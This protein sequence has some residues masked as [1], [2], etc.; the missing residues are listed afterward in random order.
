MNKL[1][2]AFFVG[3][4]FFYDCD[5]TN[6]QPSLL[7]GT[8]AGLFYRYQYGKAQPVATTDLYDYKLFSE[9]QIE[10]DPCLIKFS[11]RGYISV[12]FPFK[13]GFYQVPSEVSIVFHLPGVTDESYYA[14]SGFIEVMGV[15]QGRINAYMEADYDSLNRVEGTFILDKCY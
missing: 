10:E 5:S 3:L 13:E 8:I 1:L 2:T 4:I 14:T 12:Q 11:S 9:D 7:E 6:V 15:N